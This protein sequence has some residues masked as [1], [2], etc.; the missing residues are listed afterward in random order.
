[1]KL[2][3]PYPLDEPRRAEAIRLFNGVA[4]EVAKLV[5]HEVPTGLVPL[6]PEATTEEAELAVTDLGRVGEA[7]AGRRAELARQYASG[8]GG[9]AELLAQAASGSIGRQLAAAGPTG[10]A[11]EAGPVLS[12]LS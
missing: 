7:L 2:Y 1:M 8:T 12:Q 9:D 6:G 10:L 11:R 4:R 3:P 5:G